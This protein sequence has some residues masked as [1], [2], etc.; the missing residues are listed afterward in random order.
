MYYTSFLLTIVMNTI[1]QKSQ[2]EIYLRFF[3]QEVYKQDF[4]ENIGGFIERMDFR[5]YPGL[6]FYFIKQAMQPQNMEYFDSVYAFLIMHFSEQDSGLISEPDMKKLCI[7]LVLLFAETKSSK[8][9]TVWAFILAELPA[10]YALDK[11]WRDR[12]GSL[13]F[14]YS[15]TWELGQLWER[16]LA[17]AESVQTKKAKKSLFKRIRRTFSRGSMTPSPV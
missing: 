17:Y 16:Y 11:A 4:N 8:I 5:T 13:F 7:D 10:C 1:T 6:L 12:L 15:C 2:I 14:Q 9:R 3:S